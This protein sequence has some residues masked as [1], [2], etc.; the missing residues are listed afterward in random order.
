MTII[1]PFVEQGN[2][3][4][5]NQM[6]A[7]GYNNKPAGAIENYGAQFRSVWVV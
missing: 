3:Y 4:N 1:L 6:W 5:L 2:V 7:S